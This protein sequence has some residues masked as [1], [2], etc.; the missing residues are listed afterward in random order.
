MRFIMCSA[1]KID[2]YEI[3]KA[4]SKEVLDGLKYTADYYNLRPYQKRYNFK[5]KQ[6][7][8]QVHVFIVFIRKI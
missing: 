4:D 5:C 3:G 8:C 1:G 2:S 6:N 7:T